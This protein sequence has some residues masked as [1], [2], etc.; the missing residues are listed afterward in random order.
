MQIMADGRGTPV[1]PPSGRGAMGRHLP[2]NGPGLRA[3]LSRESELPVAIR[4]IERLG[5]T[6]GARIGTLLVD[7]TYDNGPARRAAA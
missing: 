3:C 5:Q 4:L 6:F 1:L 7:A 2:G